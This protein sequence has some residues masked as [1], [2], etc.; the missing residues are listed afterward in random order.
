MKQKK[1]DNFSFGDHKINRMIFLQYI[2]ATLIYAGMAAPMAVFRLF[3]ISAAALASAKNKHINDFFTLLGKPLFWL[4]T[5][6]L[7]LEDPSDEVKALGKKVF[8]KAGHPD[9][10]IKIYTGKNKFWKRVFNASGFSIGNNTIYLKKA[11]VEDHAVEGNTT[12][13]FHPRGL[14]A[15]IAHE[16]VHLLKRDMS[17]LVLSKIPL[18]IALSNVFSFHKNA[19]DLLWSL[20]HAAAQILASLYVTRRKEERADVIAVRLT[21]DPVGMLM[22]YRYSGDK[23]Y[24]EPSPIKRILRTHPRDKDA[25]MNIVRTFNM[26]A[27]TEKYEENGLVVTILK[28]TLYNTGEILFLANDE[29]PKPT[30]KLNHAHSPS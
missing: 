3:S 13:G 12:T 10:K 5:K 18:A 20:P 11:V 14:K 23:I 26:E 1:N 29:R 28:D 2:P 7:K 17:G 6:G 30:E 16:T 25:I 4:K 22:F 24:K 21:E 8:E 15:L 19:A 9:F 27:R